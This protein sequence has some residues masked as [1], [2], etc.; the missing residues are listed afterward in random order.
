MSLSYL[1]LGFFVK[2]FTG[3]DDLAIT[4]PM[5]SGLGFDKTRKG[6]LAFGLGIFF[7]AIVAMAIT[8]FFAQIISGFRYSK[9]LTAFL[10]FG[11]A[12]AIYFELFDS[13][14]EKGV[15][16][17]TK[18]VKESIIGR[19]LLKIFGISFTAFLI[20]SSD[21][22]IAYLPLFLDGLTQTWFAVAGVILAVIFEIF[23]VVYFAG[24][25]EKFDK[26]NEVTSIVLV[27]LGLFVLA[28]II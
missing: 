3:L 16:K 11:L 17:G 9:E 6:R 27:I 18:R 1:P 14:T 28:G 23:M 26:K 24:K 22:M 10:L 8:Y 7:A 13:H 15:K 20:S 12:T 2:I 5:V 19:S 25:I 21:D 4:I